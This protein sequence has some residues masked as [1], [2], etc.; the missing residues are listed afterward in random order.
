MPTSV[1]LHDRSWDSEPSPQVVDGVSSGLADCVRASRL[2]GSDPYLVL[3]GGGNTSYKEG[4]TVYVKASGFNLGTIT[5]EGFAPLD[6]RKLDA[7]L[8]RESLSDI[9]MVAG[10]ED[11]LLDPQSKPPSIEALL[12]NLLPFQSVLH[13]HADAIVTL[14]N[15]VHGLDLVRELYGDSVLVLDFC[16]PGFELAKQV[17]TLWAS[18]NQENIVGIVLAHHGLFTF[19]SSAEAAYERHLS[20]VKQAEDHVFDRTNVS[21]DDD[22]EEMSA[23]SWE[24][25]NDKL[26]EL[27]SAVRGTAAEELVA[28]R[29]D[30]P[31]IKMFISRS[32]LAEVSQQGPSTLE[33]VIR[34]KRVP[35]IDGDFEKYGEDYRRYFE[36]HAW[37]SA[38]KLTM[39]SSVPRVILDSE[40]GLVTIGKTEKEGKVAQDIYRHTIR[41]IEAAERFGGY[42][43]ITE[44]NAF[45]VEY[46]ELEQRKLR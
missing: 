42:R 38:K 3:H 15:T 36:A 12:H 6:R 33:H 20:L 30:S 8:A 5:A 1:T 9:E 10:F 7:L 11:A 34:T 40:L 22:E 43:T 39:L 25:G 24:Q 13:S 35:L 29:L 14:T 32:D 21:F 2:L 45:D 4:D 23:A 31:K 28:L 26:R 41:I 27:A 37:R 44:E 17:A 46:W 19:G 16:M 18:A